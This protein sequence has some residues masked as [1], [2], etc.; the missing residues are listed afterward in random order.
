LPWDYEKWQFLKLEQCHQ[1][2]VQLLPGPTRVQEKTGAA[3]FPPGSRVQ[4]GWSSYALE[5]LSIKAFKMSLT[6]FA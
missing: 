1:N 4:L 3:L 5:H 2:N 6:V